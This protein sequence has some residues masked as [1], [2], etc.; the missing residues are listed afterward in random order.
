MTTRKTAPRKAAPRRSSAAAPVVVPVA[1]EPTG[2]FAEVLAEARRAG[3]AV[4]PYEITEDLVLYP[5]DPDRTMAL[6]KYSAAYLLAQTSAVM[7]VQ[8]APTPPSDPAERLKFAEQQTAEVENAWRHAEECLTRYNEALF[9]G[10]D[11]YQRVTEFFRARPDWEKKAFEQDIKE[12]FLRL[13]HDGK[14]QACGQVVDPKAPSAAPESS[15]ASSTTGPTSL[16]ISPDTSAVPT[17]LTG[18]E[19]PAPGLS[20]TT[21]STP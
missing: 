5:P 7:L 9:G 16:G 17:P 12:K 4:E 13:P 14:C 2:R 1:G 20:S 21:S 15:T 3:M 19:V 10:P 8:T 11:V 6:D 18:S